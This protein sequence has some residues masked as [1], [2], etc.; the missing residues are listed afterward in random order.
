MA[1]LQYK[2]VS[3]DWLGKYTVSPMLVINI[4]IVFILGFYILRTEHLILTKKLKSVCLLALLRLNDSLLWKLKYF[5]LFLPS[6]PQRGHID[7][8][9]LT[10]FHTNL[11]ILPAVMEYMQYGFIA[12]GL[13][14][15]VIAALVHHKARVKLPL[16][17]YWNVCSNCMQ[18]VAQLCMFPHK[19][20]ELKMPW[21]WLK[22]VEKD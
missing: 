9:I 1:S 14:T 5:L 12:L 6:P 13:A 22:I 19:P 10:T 17:M 3:T 11:V 15:I 8:P 18:H 4:E 2:K 7:G 16:S 20:M 21:Y